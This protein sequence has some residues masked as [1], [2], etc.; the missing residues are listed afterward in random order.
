MHRSAGLG[1]E[2]LDDD[3]LDVAVPSVAGGD[4]LEGGHP[5]GPG[6]PDAHQQSGGEGDAGRSGELEGGQ[7]SGRDL[8]RGPAVG[9]QIRVHRLDHHPLAGRDRAEAEQIGEIESSGVGVG[10]QPGLLDHGAA[11]RGQVGHRGGIAVVVKPLPGGRIPVFG[12]FTQGEQGLVTT[13]VPPGPGDGQYLV[14]REIGG[15]HPGRG[16][17]EGAVATAVP[18][19]HGE[20]DE[21][22]RGEGD[23]VAM[24]RVADAAGLLLKHRHRHVHQP[25]GRPSGVGHRPLRRLGPRGGRQVRRR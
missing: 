2:V 25:G 14:E 12:A 1:Q 11:R 6:L 5:V 16:L 22:L 20:R 8:V 7:P 19:Q 9:E 18:A 24:G 10:E 3:L 15:G 21:H 4:G 23:P 17:G 13:G